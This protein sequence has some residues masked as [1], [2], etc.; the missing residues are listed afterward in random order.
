MK[1]PLK[2]IIFAAIIISIF[3]VSVLRKKTLF[4]HFTTDATSA[5]LTLIRL[6]H[7]FL[8]FIPLTINPN[9]IMLYSLEE[10]S[11]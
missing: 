8:T 5:Y 6:F 4:L 9:L 10:R 7:I 3:L 2:I 11:L 1:I